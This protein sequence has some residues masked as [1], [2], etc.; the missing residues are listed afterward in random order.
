MAINYPTKKTSYQKATSASRRGMIL[1]DDINLS[2]EYYLANNIA[3][4]HKKPTPIV[5]VDVDYPSRNKAVITKAFYKTPSTTDYNGV[6]RGYYIDFEAKE[7]TSKTSF[8]LKNIHEHQISHLKSIIEHGGIGFLIICFKEYGEVYLV[9]LDLVLKYHDLN[10]RKSIPYEE[11]KEKSYLIK[12]GYNPRLDYL[13]CVD[14]I[15]KKRF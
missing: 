4:I 3:I 12:D 9:E 1:E 7:T 2:N 15:I 6:Y 11:I 10:L 13:K 8:P 5:V 14:E